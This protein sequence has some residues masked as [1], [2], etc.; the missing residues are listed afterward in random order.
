M[1]N[2]GDSCVMKFVQLGKVVSCDSPGPYAAL[3]IHTGCRPKQS[4]KTLKRLATQL[5]PSQLF[6]TN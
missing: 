3:E 2:D 6:I 5:M 4:S 1:P